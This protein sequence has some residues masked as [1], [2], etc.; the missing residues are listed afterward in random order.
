[1]GT[2]FHVTYAIVADF[3]HNRKINPGK[4]TSDFF[5]IDFEF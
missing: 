4:E 1:M 5:L 2:V 3:P